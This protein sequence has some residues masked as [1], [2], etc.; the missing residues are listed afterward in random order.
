MIR[1]PPRSPLFP[2]PPLFRSGRL[3]PRQSE[4]LSHLSELVDRVS[5]NEASL[6]RLDSEA[7]PR[8]FLEPGL[9]SLIE[10]D[11]GSTIGYSNGRTGTDP[12]NVYTG[13]EGILRGSE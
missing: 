3:L 7:H 11:E 4:I 8:F 10:R 13:L 9:L 6:D 2:S 12:D 5:S 1:R